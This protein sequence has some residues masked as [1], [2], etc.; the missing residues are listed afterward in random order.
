MTIVLVLPESDLIEKIY[1]IYMV[2]FWTEPF[3][4]FWIFM[5]KY[6]CKKNKIRK[7]CFDEQEKFW[8]F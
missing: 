2:S 3:L 1:K 4:N 5:K 8:T 6:P 7:N